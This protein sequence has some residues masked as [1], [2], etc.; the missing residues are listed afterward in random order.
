[1]QLKYRERK[2]LIWIE[3]CRL[4]EPHLVLRT[5]FERWGYAALIS[6]IILEMV[7][8]GDHQPELFLLLS[9]ALSRLTEDRDPKNVVLLFLF[10]FLDIMG[11]LPAL[12]HCGICRRPLG[13]SVRWWWHTNQGA[14][15]CV[16]HHVEQEDQIELDLGTLVLIHRSRL[17]ALE[18]IWRLRFVQGKR[19]PLLHCLLNWIRGH[20]RKDL[21]SLKVLDQV[22][23]A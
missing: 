10:R 9:D 16:E 4:I 8:E 18:K 15:T 21:K 22:R 12:D 3:A 19:N 20:I 13:K 11:Y 17:L 23:S 7:P 2:S 6:E 1:V 5:D 14:L